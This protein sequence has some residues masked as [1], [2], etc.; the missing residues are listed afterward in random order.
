MSH[1]HALSAPHTLLARDDRR[2]SIW[3][4]TSCHCLVFSSMSDST[5]VLGTVTALRIFA[6]YAGWSGGQLD[7]ELE[8]GAWWVVPGTP[9]DLF[10]PEPD[11][12]WVRVLR[13]QPP[14]L[15]F[16]STYPEDPEQN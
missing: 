3:R 7:D 12:L 5:S 11:D 15:A 9:A 16:V 14:P 6:G 8:Q 10:S 1:R 13:R 4:S 2:G